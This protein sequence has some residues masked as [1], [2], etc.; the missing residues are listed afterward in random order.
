L[1]GE[2][3]VA[4]PASGS[5]AGVLVLHPW[6]GLN[7][8]IR[9]LCD[10]LAAEGFVALAPDL[11]GGETTSDIARA[12]ELS[13]SLDEERAWR[14][15]ANGLEQLLGN[16][17]T[18]GSRVAVLG[19]SMGTWFAFGLSAKEP[20]AI[21]AVLAFYGTGIAAFET[22]RARYLGHFAEVDDFEP[23]EGVRTLEKQI[24]D[25]GRD[26]TF[27]IYRGTGHWFFEPDVE[28]SFDQEAAQLAWE[29]TLAFL[30]STDE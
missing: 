5:G 9:D 7:G 17:A 12:K 13:E 25:A 23:L 18:L 10:R 21:A 16:P 26:V 6:W 19:L 29:R 4:V 3:Y 1:T 24:R 11:Y 20:A 22:A 28:R 14:V 8:T 2:A 30:R 15:V 27:H